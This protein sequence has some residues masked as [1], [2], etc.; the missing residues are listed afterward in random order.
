M[1][2]DLAC[3][4]IDNTFELVRLLYRATFSVNSSDFNA[5]KALNIVHESFEAQLEHF[6]ELNC[7]SSKYLHL[8]SKKNTASSLSLA[9][10]KQYDELLPSQAK[11]CISTQGLSILT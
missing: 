8:F 9:V 11:K 3:L 1:S 5:F 10:V 7:P 2:L 6:L 4:I